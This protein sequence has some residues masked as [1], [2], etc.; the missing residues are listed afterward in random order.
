MNPI[1]TN[2]IKNFFLEKMISTRLYFV[3]DNSDITDFF[4][5]VR[6]VKKIL[7]IL[8]RDRALEVMSRKYVSQ[9]HD[10]F[11]PAQFSS[12]DIYNL[13]KVDVNW[14]GIPNNSFLSKI[15][16]ENFDMIL[17]VN[18][19]HDHL[20]TYLGVFTDAPLR[21]HLCEGQF[22][23]FYNIHIRSEQHTSIEK[24][25]KNMIKY[26]AKIRHGN[27]VAIS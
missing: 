21:M 23:K 18:S 9:I 5:A 4:T 3:R 19:Y 13:R 2:F 26:L 20:C 15:K 22:D 17:D 25:Y 24:K 27:S 12:L 14:L 6:S 16:N 7:V 8:P 10:I 1:S 11:K